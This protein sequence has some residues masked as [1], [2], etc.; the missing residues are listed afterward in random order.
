MGGTDGCEVICNNRVCWM[1]A[2]LVLTIKDQ[3]QGV[4]EGRIPDVGQKAVIID[5]I[6]WNPTGSTKGKGQERDESCRAT[7]RGY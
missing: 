5:L 6:A 3:D 4:W 1:L 7:T 2:V